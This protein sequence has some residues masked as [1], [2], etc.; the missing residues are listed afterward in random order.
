MMTL[1]DVTV[2]QLP[3]LP[4]FEPRVYVPGASREPQVVTGKI[5]SSEAA[6]ARAT[7]KKE[8]TKKIPKSPERITVCEKN[9]FMLLRCS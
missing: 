7:N 9:D 1:S 8:A 4:I 6:C 3:P 5:G 2:R